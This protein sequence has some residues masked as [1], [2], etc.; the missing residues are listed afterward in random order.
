MIAVLLFVD[1]IIFIRGLFS[2]RSILL[3]ISVIEP[4]VGFI[5]IPILHS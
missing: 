1:V 5:D 3:K 2:V 4:I